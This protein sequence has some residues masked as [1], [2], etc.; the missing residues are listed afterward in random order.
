MIRVVFSDTNALIAMICF[1][2][3]LDKPS[4]AAEVAR[5]IE[6][7][8][9]ILFISDVVAV[10]LEKTIRRDFMEFTPQLEQFMALH[11]VVTL[12]APD[13][14]LLARVSEVSTD[15]ND[16]NIVA[17]AAQSAEIYDVQYLL[18]N[19]FENVH[20]PQMKAFLLEHGLIPISLYGLLK[21]LGRRA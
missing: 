5:A 20:T 2:G 17:A 12:H 21:L 3:S 9:V 4:M 10:E 11:A 13:P 1:A 7:Q 19:D 14:E 18:S 16:V 6:S 15:P 8:E